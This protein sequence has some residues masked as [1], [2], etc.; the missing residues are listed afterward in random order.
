MRGFFAIGL[1]L[2]ALLVSATIIWPPVGVAM[3]LV[4][5]MFAVIIIF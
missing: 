2:A 1:M 4:G 3:N 5:V